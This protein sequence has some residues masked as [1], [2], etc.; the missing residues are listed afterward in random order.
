M[1][2]KEITLENGEVIICRTID[3]SFGGL[4]ARGCEDGLTYYNLTNASVRILRD[5]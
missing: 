5:G 4:Q 1:L 3:D 2:M